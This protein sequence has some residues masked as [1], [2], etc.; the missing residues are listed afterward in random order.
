MELVMLSY[1][2]VLGLRTRFLVT[3]IGH[4]PVPDQQSENNFFH[5]C[6]TEVL[7]VP[8]TLQE[9]IDRAIAYSN[10]AEC[11]GFDGRRLP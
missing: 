8:S 9:P 3:G 11:C 5:L 7:L 10:A 4:V 2:P 1:V 6:C